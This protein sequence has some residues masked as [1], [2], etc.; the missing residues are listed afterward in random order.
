VTD[1]VWIFKSLPNQ[2]TKRNR[3]VGNELIKELFYTKINPKR[4]LDVGPFS[5]KKRE[6][7]MLTDPAESRSNYN[8][9]VK[10]I[11]DRLTGSLKREAHQTDLVIQWEKDRFLVPAGCRTQINT[12]KGTR[13]A[14]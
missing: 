11:L 1:E 9:R 6:Q 14:Y 4:W 7:G 12:D 2:V 10:S 3:T 8:G 5:P 13:Y